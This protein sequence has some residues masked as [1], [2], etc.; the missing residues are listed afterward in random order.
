[1]SPQL[2]IYETATPVTTARHGKCFVE[3]GNTYAFTRSVNSVPLMATEFPQAALEYPLVFSDGGEETLPVVILG[4]R[5]QE[6]L[7]LG[8]DETWQARYIPAFVR[9][10]PF[11]FSTSQD[12]QTYT[13]C[14]DEAFPGLNFQGRGV[15]LFDEGGKPSAYTENVMKFLKS[16]SDQALQTQ[17]F[18][19]RLRELDL[20]E[21][22]Q[23]TFTLGSGEKVSLRGFQTVNRAKLKAL[24]D[25]TLVALARTDALELIYL[26]LQSMNNLNGLAGRTGRKATAPAR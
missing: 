9:R 10:Y 22:V 2:L 12:G 25:A 1:M 7:Y 26:H 24:D 11:V 19:R 8:A 4:T 21:P 14:I 5:Q 23:A 13:L 20:L 18:C 17:A 15:A 3:V 6:N 16:Y